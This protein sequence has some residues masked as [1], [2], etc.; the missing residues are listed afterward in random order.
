MSC[1]EWDAV[2]A[3]V[4]RGRGMLGMLGVLWRCYGDATDATGERDGDRGTGA[5]TGMGVGC[6]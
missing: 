6:E 1:H 2:R 3:C 4:N 5:G